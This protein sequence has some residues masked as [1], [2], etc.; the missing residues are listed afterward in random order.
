[1]IKSNLL[2][3]ISLPFFQQSMLKMPQ[4]PMDDTTIN[5]QAYTPKTVS[6]CPAEKLLLAQKQRKLTGNYKNGHFFIPLKKSNI[7]K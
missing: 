2:N 5:R 1:M 3:H 7:I 4:N 6:N